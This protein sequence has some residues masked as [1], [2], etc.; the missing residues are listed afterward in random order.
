[1]VQSLWETAWRFLR[2]LNIEIPYDAGITL[3]SIILKETKP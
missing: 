2:K 1:M 3:K